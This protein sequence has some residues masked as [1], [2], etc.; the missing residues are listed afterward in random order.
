MRCISFLSVSFLFGILLFGCVTSSAQV[1]EAPPKPDKDGF[2]SIFNGK[3]MAG[4]EGKEGWWNVEDGALTARSTE[5]RPCKIHNYLMWRGGTA[6]GDFELKLSY[7]IDG[8]NS[9]VQF[10]SRELDNWDIDCAKELPGAVRAWNHRG[11]RPQLSTFGEP[12]GYGRSTG[13]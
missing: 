1:A 10:R 5:E 9:G 4:W 6:E 12:S 3:D 2:V 7:K 8:G 13:L 11:E